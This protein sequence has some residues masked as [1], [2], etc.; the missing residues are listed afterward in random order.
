MQWRTL[1]DIQEEAI[2][3][4]FGSDDHLLITAATAGGKTEAAFLPV[5]SKLSEQNRG[6]V[7]ALYVSPLK[8]LINDQF[9]RLDVLCE[10]SEIPVIKWHGDVASAKK[11]AAFSTENT[12]I[13]ITPE[14]IES[15]MVNHSEHLKDLFHNLSFIIIDEVHA[16]AG[17]DRGEHLRSLLYRVCGFSVNKVRFIGLS[18]TVGDPK[19]T[20]EWM[21]LNDLNIT[22]IEGS[23][24]REIK[25]LI[26]G[27]KVKL[28]DDGLIENNEIP[29]DVIKYFYRKPSLIFVNAKRRIEEIADQVTRKLKK[30]NRLNTFF[31]HHGSLSKQVRED[32]E[33]EMRKGLDNTVICS[34]TLEMGIDMGSIEIAGQVGCP[35]SVSSLVQRMGRSG[36]K[37]GQSAVL[38]M[39][40]EEE[41]SYKLEDRLF[42][43]LIKSIAMSELMFAKWTEPPVLDDINYSVLVQQ[44]LSVIKQ[45]G[46]IKAKDIYQILSSK[47]AF[48]GLLQADYAS[49]LK[50]MGEYDLIEQDQDLLIL[51]IEGERIVKRMDFYAVFQTPEEYKVVYDSRHIG[52]INVTAG[53]EP[54]PFLILA[55]KRWVIDSIDDSA[56]VI[57]V[58]PSEGGKLAKFG[59]NVV[60]SVH[61]LVHKKMLE[62]Y[63]SEQPYPYLDKN[64]TSMLESARQAAKGISIRKNMIIQDGESVIWFL[65]AG[66][67]VSNTLAYIGRTVKGYRVRDSG[68]YLT[69]EN[70]TVDEVVSFYKSLENNKINLVEL[71]LENDP[72]LISKYDRY[73]PA[74]LLA[75]AYVKKYMG[76]DVLYKCVSFDQ[77]QD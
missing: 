4:V 61:P 38:I 17:S 63:M 10:Y 3:A 11:K 15:L 49:L 27:Y 65:F 44:T 14:S 21:C 35:F 5:L 16:F 57:Y 28:N 74:E 59:G 75:R 12:V 41:E 26:K 66:T 77:M 47:G 7:F 36:R 25:Y 40:I 23:G 58:K 73:V 55:G 24:G 20:A 1:R 31:V 68:I 43:D 71:L 2:H 46:A 34:S 32:A 69:F 42:T 13:L 67:R 54:E 72:I 9:E 48:N 50:N 37:E 45:K 18:A 51:G 8:A 52:N 64:A 29:D 33:T 56:K 30:S 62:I 60:Y 76:E 70:T 6:K 22:Y 53:V 19:Q 39:F